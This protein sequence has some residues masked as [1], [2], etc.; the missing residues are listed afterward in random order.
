MEDLKCNIE[1]MNGKSQPKISILGEMKALLEHSLVYGLG[2]FASRAI[3][4]LMI[5]IYTRYL[6]PADY[7]I[8]ELVDLVLAVAGLILYEL[9]VE[10]IFK[11]YYDYSDIKD[12]KELISSALIIHLMI[13][14]LVSGLA[15]LYVDT[16][17]QLIFG[18]EEYRSYLL[19]SFIGF[20]FM[21]FKAI[22][23]GY[24]RIKQQPVMFVIVSLGSLIL[25]L[26][27]NIYLIVFRQMGVYGVLYS[28]LI[29]NAVVAIALGIKTFVEVGS[30]F[31][32][33]K[34]VVMV[35]FGSPM[36]PS[37][38][39]MFSLNFSNRFFLTKYGTLTDVGLFALGARFG[40]MIHVM[41]IQPFLEIWDAKMFQIAKQANPEKIYARTLT[42]FT[43][44][45]T[46]AALGMSLLIKDVLTI[47][48]DPSFIN[49]YKIVP[50]LSLGYLFMG[51][52][53]HFY[54]G[55]LIKSKTIYIG[56]V[57][58]AT[59]ILNFILNWIVIKHFGI[60]GAAW[61]LCA[62]YLMMSVATY[63]ISYRLYPI[64]YEW[65]RIFKIGIVAAGIYTFSL[66]VSEDS[67]ALSL[68]LRSMMLLGYPVLLGFMKFYRKEEIIKIKELPKMVTGKI[69]A[70]KSGLTGA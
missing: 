51:F 61:V 10:A 31:S 46:F 36:I 42:Y 68:S 70:F 65:A 23:L 66:M 40:F 15:L 8:I 29:T 13:S 41:V 63:V 57:N 21:Q 5:P 28:N 33:K 4:F 14:L 64:K 16:A 9:V 32:W 6:T 12:K 44:V 22:P 37:G 34:I 26:S 52:Y 54:V 49:A 30:G 1:N 3:G 19:I 35:K 25:G 11:F 2:N 50:I 20:I 48:A 67:M 58:G 56:I 47:I 55:I 69:K 45:A 39:G 17:S 60:S 18:S 43:Y 62:S 53:Y 24:L 27:L 7:G 38:I 59:A